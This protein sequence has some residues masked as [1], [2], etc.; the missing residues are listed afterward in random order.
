CRGYSK[1]TCFSNCSQ[2]ERQKQSVVQL[3]KLKKGAEIYKSVGTIL[4]KSDDKDGLKKE[5]EDKKETLE[6]RNKT[7][8]NQEK[9]LREMHQ[10]LQKELTEALQKEKA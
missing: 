9:T 2:Q 10:S 5:L 6:I 8:A 4:V 3:S 7:L 1:R